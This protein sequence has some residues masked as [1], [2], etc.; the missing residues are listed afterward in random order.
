[1]TPEK[2]RQLRG[3]VNRVLESVDPE[4][5]CEAGQVLPY[6]SETNTIV[7]A[8][9]RGTMITP[10]Y[11]RDVWLYWFGTGAD[12]HGIVS[13]CPMPMRPEFKNISEQIHKILTDP[14]IAPFK[15]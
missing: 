11:I 12:G 10:E 14:L 3:L 15:P 1:M 8:I 5:I 6:K 13:V 4:G 9:Q 7:V 2:L